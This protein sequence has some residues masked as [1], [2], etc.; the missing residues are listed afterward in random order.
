MTRTNRQ[1]DR[2]QVHVGSLTDSGA[3]PSALFLELYSE[4]DE[5]VTKARWQVDGLSKNVLP[6]DTTSTIPSFEEILK[7]VK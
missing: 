2:T 7:G 4:P 1:I 6:D 3:I 5:S